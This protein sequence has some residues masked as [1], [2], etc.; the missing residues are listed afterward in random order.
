MGSRYEHERHNGKQIKAAQIKMAH[1]HDST[2]EKAPAICRQRYA[3][4]CRPLANH[5]GLPGA[6]R[7]CEHP[8]LGKRRI[9]PCRARSRRHDKKGPRVGSCWAGYK[10]AAAAHRGSGARR[11]SGSKGA[12]SIVCVVVPSARRPQP[13]RNRPDGHPG[14]CK[15]PEGCRFSAKC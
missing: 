15:S 11:L 6:L 2:V 7:Q 8:A 10:K 5:T 12:S 1:V 9:N 13:T 14:G 4:T 3:A